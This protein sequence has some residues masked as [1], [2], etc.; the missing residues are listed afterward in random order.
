MM[1][2]GIGLPNALP[3]VAGSAAVEWARAAEEC[4]YHAVA[5]VDRVAFANHDA[6]ISLAAA[7]VVTERVQLLTA[8]SLG[9]L[10]SP[11]LLAK[12]AATLDH[13]AR[14]RFV[15]GV[16]V[17]S[18]ED[19]YVAA[20]ASELFH[21]RGAALDQQLEQMSRIWRAEDW[22]GGPLVGPEPLTAGGPRVLLG[23]ASLATWARTARYGSGWIS[24]RGGPEGFGHGAVA[25][26]RAWSV[27]G[28]SEEPL[29]GALVYFSLG[30]NGATAAEQFIGQYYGYAP[31]VDSLLASVNVTPGMVRA[32]VSQYA[33]LGCGQLLFFPCAA[34]LEQ[35]ELLSEAMSGLGV[36]EGNALHNLSPP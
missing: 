33:D 17:G 10:R 13:L 18:R 31:F 29:L 8:I 28:R 9:P 27:A 20:G 26:R 21:H 15:L 32:T 34:A 35:V 5:S 24:G 11:G 16:G 6:F 2:V 4:G 30:P 19:D 25:V 23:G 12:T 36:L 1:R 14:G 7:A 22:D 3:G